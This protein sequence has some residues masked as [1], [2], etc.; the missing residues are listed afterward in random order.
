[1]PRPNKLDGEPPLIV[2]LRA[3]IDECNAS[4]Y[5]LAEKAGIDESAIRKFMAR[6]RSL[7]LDSAARLCEILGLRVLRPSKPRKFAGR[8]RRVMPT[9]EGLLGKVGAV[10]GG[11]IERIGV[12]PE[13]VEIGAPD[14]LEQI[15]DN[16]PADLADGVMGGEVDGSE[17]DH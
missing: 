12:T 4:P 17:S 8:T 13:L 5:R 9:G 2:E 11:S 10:A 15:I 7:S 14:L 6:T 3:S 1:M 16:G